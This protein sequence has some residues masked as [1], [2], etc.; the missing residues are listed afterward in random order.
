[1]PASFTTRQKHVAA[2]MTGP[3]GKFLTPEIGQGTFEESLMLECIKA[4]QAAYGTDSTAQTMAQAR[5]V[6]SE[7]NRGQVISEFDMAYNGH[8]SFQ[9]W[10]LERDP[11]S[12]SSARQ[13]D[14]AGDNKALWLLAGL[15]R[16]NWCLAGFPRVPHLSIL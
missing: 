12:A 7:S 11:S 4:L 6:P 14:P 5:A 8:L 1:M 3:F 16:L 2:S 13:S 15:T 10:P 9:V